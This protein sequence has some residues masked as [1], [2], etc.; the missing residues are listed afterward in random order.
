MAAAK[1]IGISILT[2]IFGSLLFIGGANMNDANAYYCAEKKIIMDCV[3]FNS[4]DTYTR[5][6]PNLVGN[7]GY[8]D[9]ASGWAKVVNDTKQPQQKVVIGSLGRP[10]VEYCTDICRPG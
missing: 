7:T 6:Y 3:R 9:C 10:L 2:L 1:T 8:K 4:G 5:C